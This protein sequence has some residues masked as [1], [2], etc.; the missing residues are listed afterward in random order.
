MKK[1]KNYFLF[2][3]EF[4]AFSR[5]SLW[6]GKDDR[7]ANLLENACDAKYQPLDKNPYQNVND[8]YKQVMDTIFQ[9]TMMFLEKQFYP[10]VIII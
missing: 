9:R 8:V 5:F 2:S 6:N 4:I 3:Q 7:L 10:C 1:G